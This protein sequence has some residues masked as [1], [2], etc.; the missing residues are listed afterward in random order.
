[1]SEPYET[2]E[3]TR[4]LDTI[5]AGYFGPPA[6]MDLRGVDPATFTLGLFYGFDSWQHVR[7]VANNRRNV[8]TAA[9]HWT[10]HHPTPEFLSHVVGTDERAS[11]HRLLLDRA[12]PRCAVCEEQLRR[13]AAGDLDR[14]DSSALPDDIDIEAWLL[15]QPADAVRRSGTDVPDAVRSLHIRDRADD[16]PIT[17]DHYAG[18]DWRITVRDPHARRARLWVGWTSGH[19]TEH[20]V[21][22]ENDLAEINAEAPDDQARPERVRVQVTDPPDPR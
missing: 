9:Q 22:F 2:D 16:R 3:I 7:V 19:T 8:A 10:E 14:V 17:A 15:F 5:F 21:T 13:L 18:R 12:H 1:M 11:G 6:E 20:D 4:A